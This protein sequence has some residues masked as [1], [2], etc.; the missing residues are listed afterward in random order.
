MNKMMKAGRVDI[1]CN[2]D[3]GICGEASQNGKKN[4][5][6][7]SNRRYPFIVNL[8]LLYPNTNRPDNLY[9][10]YTCFS[11]LTMTKEFN[12]TVFYL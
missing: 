1:Y 11:T 8:N 10:H 7:E 3:S 2:V 5:F 12:F 9:A 4:W 6:R